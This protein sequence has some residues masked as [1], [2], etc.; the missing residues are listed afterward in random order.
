MPE[1][2]VMTESELSEVTALGHLL[3]RQIDKML[4]YLRN[5]QDQLEHLA[6]GEFGMIPPLDNTV[7]KTSAGFILALLL[8]PDVAIEIRTNETTGE[9]RPGE[10]LSPE[11][12]HLDS[13]PLD[14]P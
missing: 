14:G 5:H 10:G 9:V 1:V 12:P 3:Q 8:A 7:I 11:H 4:G 13:Q 6:A 2:R